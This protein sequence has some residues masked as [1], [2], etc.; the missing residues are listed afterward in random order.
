MHP[1]QS[2]GV[3][4]GAERIYLD[5][6][7]NGPSPPAGLAGRLG[8]PEAELE[9]PLAELRALG[10]LACDG[11][12]LTPCP[13][14][15]AMESLAQEHSRKAAA[16]WENAASLSQLWALGAGQRWYTETLPSYAAAQTV[17]D[18]AQTDAR[19]QVRAM[20]MGVLSSTRQR[21]VAGLFEALARGVQYQVIYG[22]PVLHDPIGRRMVQKCVDA[23]EEARFMPHVPLN[24]TIVDDRWALVAARAPVAGRERIAAVVVHHQSPFLAA[25]T[26]IFEAFW[27]TAVP[28][29][30]RAAEVEVSD[31]PSQETRRLLSYLSAGLTD[32]S[33]AREFGVS[34]RT[35]ARRI[36][37]LQELLGAQTRFQLGVQAAHQ[38]WL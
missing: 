19:E 37:R 3:S 6:V 20:T 35:I 2:L 38:G 10:L 32:E 5:L 22:T 14:Q 29:T 13:P 1:L 28:L 23:G 9:R 16:A 12:R 31:A 26:G 27:R 33:I 8:T 17:L 15:L 25:L 36:S 34:E 24:L 11:E 21:I 4:A 7:E 18:R 30:S